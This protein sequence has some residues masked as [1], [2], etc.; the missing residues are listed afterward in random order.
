MT[1]KTPT[2][3]MTPTVLLSIYALS[4][5]YKCTVVAASYYHMTDM[6]F[7][8]KV[9]NLTISCSR[10]TGAAHR[11]L[12]TPPPPPKGREIPPWKKEEEL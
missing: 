8:M 10:P 7:L 9:R 2:L 4:L 3:Y 11:E 6:A 1:N 5:P 12:A